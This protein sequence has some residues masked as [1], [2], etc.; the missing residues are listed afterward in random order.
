MREQERFNSLNTWPEKS[1]SKFIPSC[2]ADMDEE[3]ETDVA[4]ETPQE[5]ADSIQ[6]PESTGHGVLSKPTEKID[7]NGKRSCTG[8]TA[9]TDKIAALKADHSRIVESLGVDLNSKMAA[10]TILQRK[11][12]EGRARDNELRTLYALLEEKLKIITNLESSVE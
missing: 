2:F 3:L 8:A 10:I 11:D 9:E 6:L 4:E 5:I 1:V 7:R 12:E